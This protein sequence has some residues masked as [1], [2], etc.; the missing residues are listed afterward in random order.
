MVEF[1]SE[2]AKRGKNKKQKHRRTNLVKLA[3]R[4]IQKVYVQF[5]RYL[6]LFSTEEHVEG[7]LSGTAQ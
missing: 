2:D 5:P 3:V 4:G 6:S 1:I 7:D